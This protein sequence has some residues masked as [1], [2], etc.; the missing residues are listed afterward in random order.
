MKNRSAGPWA[1]ESD[2]S[3]AE[4]GDLVQLGNG[5]G[6]FYHTPVVVSAGP[7]GIFVAAHTFDAW[8][9]PLESYSFAEIRLLHIRGARR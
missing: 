5:S 3:R 8:M 7:G 6:H 4:P 1:E 9:R 2:L